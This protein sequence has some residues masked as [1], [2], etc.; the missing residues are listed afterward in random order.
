MD[1]FITGQ[2]VQPV[3]EGEHE[4]AANGI[5]AGFQQVIQFADALH[6]LIAIQ[7]IIA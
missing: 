2:F 5:G 7:Q 1:A 3:F 4:V 6:I